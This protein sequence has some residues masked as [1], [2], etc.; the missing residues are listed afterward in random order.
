MKIKN[1]VA[2]ER[3]RERLISKGANSLSDYELLAIMLGSGTKEKSVLEL[4]IELIEKYGLEKLFQMDYKELKKIKGI[5]EAKA[6]KLM[7]C[8]EI[9]KRCIAKK[10]NLI[11]LSNAIEVYQY[12]QSDFLYLKTE[13]IMILYVDTKCRVI[14]KSFLNGDQVAKIELPVKKII[15]EAIKWN[16]YGIFLIHNHPSGDVMPSSSDID[17]T[18]YLITLLNE[19]GIAFLDHIIVSDTNFFSLM[20]NKIII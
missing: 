17:S 3:P 12:V 7:S 11:Q 13:R 10:D 8:F 4:S 2:K 19:I 16:A 14:Q 15:G 1:I 9:A 6:S 5:K 18:H 20:D